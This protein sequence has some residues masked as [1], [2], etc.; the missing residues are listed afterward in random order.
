[1][2]K[3]KRKPPASPPELQVQLPA[4]VLP[5]ATAEQEHQVFV[6]LLEGNSDYHINQAIEA[7]MPEIDA[8]ALI[9]RIVARIEQAGQADPGAVRGWCMEAYRHVYS[10]MMKTGDYPAAARVIKEL[11][12]LA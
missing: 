11:A 4:I 5:Q 12:K 3:R 8:A 2:A 9:G 7:T 6:W 10:L 1:M